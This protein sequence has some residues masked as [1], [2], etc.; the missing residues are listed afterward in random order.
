MYKL[1]VFP[2]YYFQTATIHPC[3]VNRLLTPLR[4]VNQKLQ[5]EGNRAFLEKSFHNMSF[6]DRPSFNWNH[7]VPKRNFRT[8]WRS[9]STTG[10]EANDL[11][12]R[13]PKRTNGPLGVIK[14]SGVYTRHGSTSSSIPSSSS[15]SHASSSKSIS[16]GNAT[17]PTTIPTMEQ[18]LQEYQ[19]GV[20]PQFYDVKL[21]ELDKPGMSVWHFKSIC[22]LLSE[23]SRQGLHS[24]QFRPPTYDYSESPHGWQCKLTVFH[25]YTTYFLV[26]QSTKK[27]AEEHACKQALVWLRDQDIM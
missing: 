19:S 9:C 18:L 20:K 16:T 8:N 22:S 10:N 13:P 2:S 24:Q 6:R 12:S 17:R 4:L 3:G 15:A 5:S 14:D 25:P 27:K 21:K 23:Q 1:T 26:T 11:S 7:R